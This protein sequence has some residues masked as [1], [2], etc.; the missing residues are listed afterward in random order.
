MS[1][2]MNVT[3]TELCTLPPRCGADAVTSDGHVVAFC[4]EPDRR[5]RFYWD[6][7]ATGA[8]FDEFATNRDGSPIV[9]ISEDGAHVAYVGIRG[10][11][12]FVG[13]DDREDPEFAE[14]S[15]SVPLVFGGA[16]RHLAYGV[17]TLGGDARLILDG[18]RIGTERRAPIAAVFSPDGG[19]LAYVEMRGNDLS[20]VEFRIVLDS[21]PGDWF[22]GMR[23]AAGAMQFSPDGRRFAYYAVDGGGGARWFVDGMPQRLV[24]DDPTLDP[25]RRQSIGVLDKPLLARFSPDSKRFAYATDAGEGAAM[26]EDDASGPS[27][28][29]IAGPVFSPDSLQLAYVAKTVANTGV[30]VLDNSIIGE[31]PETEPEDPVFSP[32]SRHLGVGLLRTERRFL[33]TRDLHTV[34]VD[35]R[36]FP[37]EP[38]DTASSL[39]SFSPD[40][41][42]VAWWLQRGEEMYLVIDGLVESG[43]GILT[44]DIRFNAQ[45][46]IV[47][48]TRVGDKE[49]I[50]VEDRPGPLADVV[51]GLLPIHEVYPDERGLASSV[52]FRLSPNGAH[53]AWAGFFGD[54]T[55]PVF[56]DEV[57]PPFGRFY[58]CKITDDGAA[59]WW[60]ERGRTV[61]RIERARDAT[62]ST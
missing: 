53:I 10:D 42:R 41:T 12:Y 21:R 20:D 34:A 61:F 13:R 46:Q 4:R 50:A 49:T 5:W 62:A 32:D 45:G 3:L 36:T 30:L 7:A 39:F 48:A 24:F 1:T 23:N 52:P 15:H 31:W 25:E 26:F 14:F 59:V 22:L 55:R 60:A 43:I 54:E 6:G 9:H 57:G 11:K 17:T 35:G 19:R 58:D 2:D 27:F 40:G 33:G 29:A 18:E 28:D 38:A 51:D 44:S 47:H 37:E 16:G 8:P 56:D